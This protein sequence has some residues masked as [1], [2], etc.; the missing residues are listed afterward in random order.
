MV[1]W[2]I[3][4]L[5]IDSQSTILDVG[6]GRGKYTIEIAKRTGQSGLCDNLIDVICSIERNHPWSRKLLS[7]NREK[8]ICPFAVCLFLDFYVLEPLEGKISLVKL[9]FASINLNSYVNVST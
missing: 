5:G 7:S 2:L 6:C 3:K 8:H 9:I 4:K 1:D